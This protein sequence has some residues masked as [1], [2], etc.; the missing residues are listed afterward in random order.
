MTELQRKGLIKYI[1]DNETLLK[2]GDF[3]KLIRRCPYGIRDQLIKLLDDELNTDI[4]TEIHYQTFK[5]SVLRN[6]VKD[7]IKEPVVYY[8]DIF[9]NKN[10]TSH[11][12]KFWRVFVP[13][14]GG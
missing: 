4:S 3:D 7:I 5:W 10:K 12:I 13:D 6:L 2:Q 14:M 8:D 9:Y 11:S 1:E